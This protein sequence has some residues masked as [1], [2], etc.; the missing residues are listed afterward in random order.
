[1]YVSS[2]FRYF[3]YHHPF[4]YLKVPLSSKSILSSESIRQLLSMSLLIIICERKSGRFES[5]LELYRS[6]RP[7]GTLDLDIFLRGICPFR[8]SRG[9]F[10]GTSVAVCWKTALGRNSMVCSRSHRSFCALEGILPTTA[11]NPRTCL[12]YAE[13][14]FEN[15]LL[16]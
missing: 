9:I 16:D 3:T 13:L 12:Y 5:S 4:Y 15:A 10:C 8:E 6:P 1:M 11:L 7:P 2:V 14:L